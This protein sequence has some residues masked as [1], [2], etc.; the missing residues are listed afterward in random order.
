MIEFLPW[1]LLGAEISLVAF[2]LPVIFAWLLDGGHSAASLRHS[3]PPIPP[4][5]EEA[6]RRARYFEDIQ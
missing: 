5:R 1:L 4:T 3:M 6:R 2:A